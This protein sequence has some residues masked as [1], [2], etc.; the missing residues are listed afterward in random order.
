M[1]NNTNLNSHSGAEGEGTEEGN[2]RTQWKSKEV[3]RFTDDSVSLLDW[4]VPAI[5]QVI[6]QE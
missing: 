3:C 2:D 1:S 4:D 5:H 6:T